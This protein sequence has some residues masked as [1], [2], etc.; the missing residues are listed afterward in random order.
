MAQA[1]RA[2]E[3]VQTPRS[4]ILDSL[5]RAGYSAT[6]AATMLSITQ[7]LRN[8]SGTP[9]AERE[10]LMNRY[11]NSSLRSGAD[12]CRMANLWATSAP[13]VA[14]V[15]G[16]S[17]AQARRIAGTITHPPA[18]PVLE[19]VVSGVREMYRYFT[20]ETYL[21]RTPRRFENK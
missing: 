6:E 1:T 21:Q 11:L 12:V 8:F 3:E 7:M 18:H 4:I 19:H 16:L 10:R 2:P 14:T 9:P 20:D 13:G 15:E 5:M 17:L